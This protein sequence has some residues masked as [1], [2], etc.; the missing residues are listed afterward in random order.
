MKAPVSIVTPAVADSPMPEERVADYT[1]KLLGKWEFA[2]PASQ[3]A[4]ELT[5]RERCMESLLRYPNASEEP[6]DYRR[7][8]NP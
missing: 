8:V 6:E 1:A 4:D 2:L 7:R 3:A 5:D